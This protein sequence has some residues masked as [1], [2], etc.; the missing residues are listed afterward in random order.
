[1]SDIQLHP[2]SYKDKD[3]QILVINNK[4]Y[5]EI[6]KSYENN[7]KMLMKSGLYEELTQ[8]GHLIKHYETTKSETN[9]RLIKPEEIFISYPYEWCFSQLKDAALL[10]LE[11]QKTAL[12][13]NM[14]LKDANCYNVQFHN[15][16]P[17]FID[18]ASF[19]K[20]EEGT[21]WQAYKQF[22]MNFIA[23]LALM[24]YKN[25][26]LVC[27]L[28]T[29][30]NGIDLNLASSLLPLK[31]IFNINI[32][33]HIHQHA[34][35]QKKY[36]N[37]NKKINI[38]YSKLQMVI[39]ID[40]LIK[41]IKSIKMKPK[42]SCWKDYYK[43]TN[44]T[45]NSFHQKISIINEYKAELQPHSLVDIGANNGFF[46]RLFK[47]ICK[48]II[49]IDSDYNAIEKNYNETKNAK[50]N[51]IYPLV[52]D[53]TNPTPNLGWNNEE[54]F[55]FYDRIKNIDMVMA[56]AIIHHL[57]ISNNIPLYNIAKT[58]S[59]TGKYLIIEFIEKEDSQIQKL[60]KN[61]QDI[62]DDY[63]KENFEKTFSEFY[64]IKR[65]NPIPDT[66]R[67]LYLMQRIKND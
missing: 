33:L 18:T 27:L 28:K 22:C 9:K 51:N 26:C 40:N 10:T 55:S 23:P 52:I 19:E 65:K 50:E 1:M 30:I 60:L 14:S 34:K 38:Q 35:I 15:G 45:D 36:E 12:K 44:Y 43:K 37:N 58:F 53:F 2:A 25:S 3:S 54:R 49:C 6:K 39:L 62:F 21:I 59:K 31:S 16:K 66:F 4:I 47:N 64:E 46:S 8:K 41:T 48:Q 61:R 13:Y 5:R 17:I 24:A 32:L 63:T 67:T 7:Y 57:A 20:Y 29:Y 56:L 11:I 42:Y